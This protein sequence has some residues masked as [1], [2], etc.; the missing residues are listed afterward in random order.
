MLLNTL[1]ISAKT[2]PS[3]PQATLVGSSDSLQI[4]LVWDSTVN[5]APFGFQAAIIK[6]AQEL[7]KTLSDNITLNIGISCTGVGGSA[8]GGPTSGRNV[9]Y[10]IFRDYLRSNVPDGPDI[11]NAIPEVS[12]IQGESN[13][14]L[15]DAQ[16]KL[17][18]FETTDNLD[19]SATFASDIPLNSL[20]NVALHEITHGMG[21]IA[22]N[23]TPDVFNLFRFTSP[24]TLLLT[25]NI[26]SVPAYFSIDG[27]KT[28]LADYGISS[29]PSD[30]L[31]TGVQGNND[32]LNE[33]YGSASLQ[34]LSTVDLIQLEVLGFTLNSAAQASIT[35]DVANFIKT[36]Q[37]GQTGILFLVDT[38]ANISAN[39]DSI[40]A[41]VNN[42]ISITLS[43]INTLLN[44][45]FNQ[46]INDSEVLAK[47]TTPCTFNVSE[48]SLANSSSL[49][50]NSQVNGIEILDSTNQI[51]LNLNT[52]N[53][54]NGQL[55]AIS[56]TDSNT[57]E[58]TSEQ[59]FTDHT[60]LNKISGAYNL[61]ITGTTGNDFLFDTVN[62]NATLM[63]GEGADTFTITGIDTINDLGKGGTD[64]LKVATGGI[65]NASLDSAWVASTNTINNGSVNITTPGLEVNLS[66]VTKGTTGYKIT[67]TGNATQLIGSALKDL[68]IGGADNDTL[69]GGLGKDVLKGGLGRDYLNGG[70]GNDTLIGGTGKDFFV[71]NTPLSNKSNID[72]ITDFSS[73]KDHLQL[74]KAIFTGLKTVSGAGNG[75]A[76][77]IAEFIAS[78]TA[79][80][81]TTVNSH[82]IYNS[83]SGALYYDADGSGKGTALELAILGTTTHPALSAADIFVI[84]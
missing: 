15:W 52:L 55:E 70:L 79:V 63:G 4:N 73:G 59:S 22:G 77:K 58:I 23:G 18:G 8:A 53:D 81:G 74:S 17:G 32:P 56:L 80:H 7:C 9:P 43:G 29:D 84:A 82:L 75:T 60:V 26:P 36:R 31:N 5:N 25:E 46:Y 67:N 62:S 30:F 69:I 44:L 16:L 41:S 24:G 40:Q 42:L 83:T 34:S 2:S 35:A 71:F 14:T 65:A 1:S 6:A 37:S 20:T 10:A 38:S 19:G 28:H 64:V 47:I 76:L 39:L 11:F 68:I 66:A 72:L 13:I 21:R 78:P 12:T 45:A 57:L 48:V 61:L 54:M 49:L 33:F 50:T 27:G 51:I 3:V